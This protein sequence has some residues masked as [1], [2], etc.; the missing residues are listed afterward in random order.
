M[1][2]PQATTSAS[3]NAAPARSGAR[4]ALSLAG[5]LVSTVVTVAMAFF[6]HLIVVLGAS[7][8]EDHGGASASVLIGLFQFGLLVPL[9]LLATAWALAFKPQSGDRRIV[10]CF[11]AP[12]SV[13]VLSVVTLAFSG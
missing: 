9:C 6:A 11:C 4:T 1:S 2:N 8:A 7:A 13:L 5:P 10:Y 12:V 3:A